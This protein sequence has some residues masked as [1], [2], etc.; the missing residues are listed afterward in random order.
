[1]GPVTPNMTSYA[2]TAS[3]SDKYLVGAQDMIGWMQDANQVVLS[4]S[5]GFD[6]LIMIEL[7]ELMS[8]ETVDANALNSTLNTFV[9][10]S[11]AAQ[12]K[13]QIKLDALTPPERWDIGGWRVGSMERKIHAVTLDYYKSIPEMLKQLEA[14]SDNLTKIVQAVVDGQTDFDYNKYSAQMAQVTREL[15]RSES[16]I[17]RGMMAA[18]PENSPN[19]WYHAIVVDSNEVLVAETGLL[20]IDYSSGDAIA[21]R[22]EIG[23]QSIRALSD[24]PDLIEKGRANIPLFV[25]QIDGYIEQTQSE[26]Q[27]QFLSRMVDIT[28]S[29]SDAFD[30]EQRIHELQLENARLYAS[31]EPDTVIDPVIAENDAEFFMLTDERIRQQMLRMSAVGG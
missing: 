4:A 9:E 10:K 12:I 3:A 11:D 16:K 24:V 31:E 14:A 29:F 21:Q 26:Q 17:L 13:A 18:I 19:Y 27:I 6:S 5:E 22:Q 20:T 30:I 23:L 2:Q 15:L 28:R 8:V 7:I 25:K 1:M